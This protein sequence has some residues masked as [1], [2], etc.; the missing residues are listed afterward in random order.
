MEDLSS[1]LSEGR[2]HWQALPEWVFP[3]FPYSELEKS[4]IWILIP[5]YTSVTFDEEKKDGNSEE[6]LLD[7]EILTEIQR[8]GDQGNEIYKSELK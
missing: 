5:S 2:L 3:H 6:I 1:S 8:V 7:K 4:L